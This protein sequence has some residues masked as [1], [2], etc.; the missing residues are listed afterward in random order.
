MQRRN[1]PLQ[2]G[3]TLVFSFSVCVWLSAQD[4][5]ET[6][7]TDPPATATPKTE[8]TAPAGKSG[9]APAPASKTETKP[10]E[11]TGTPTEKPAEKVEANEKK[12]PAPET[13]PSKAPR[14]N[15]PSKAGPLSQEVLNQGDFPNP[16]QPENPLRARDSFY[17]KLITE[18]YNYSKK[19]DVNVRIFRDRLA[20]NKVE[21][22]NVEEVALSHVA[23]VNLGRIAEALMLRKEPAGDDLMTLHRH[24]GVVLVNVGKKI[25]ELPGFPKDK[26]KAQLEKLYKAM[27]K[28]KPRLEK[29]VDDA[30]KAKDPK[31]FYEVEQEALAFLDQAEYL[32][33]W[34]ASDRQKLAV[35][36]SLR[37]KYRAS[38]VE[39][40]RAEVNKR[41]LADLQGVDQKGFDLDKEILQAVAGLRSGTETTWRES[42]LKGP[43]MIDAI[44]DEW[45]AMQPRMLKHQCF[46]NCMGDGSKLDET[47]VHVN[48]KQYEKYCSNVL[49]AIAVIIDSDASDCKPEEV[50][51][52][53]LAYLE[54]AAALQAQL[55]N[56]SIMFKIEASLEALAAKNPDFAKQVKAYKTVTQPLLDWR[57]K[58]TTEQAE[59]QR[60]DMPEIGIVTRNA[61]REDIKMQ[62]FVRSSEPLSI[63]IYDPVLPTL[64]K[65]YGRLWGHAVACNTVISNPATP[66]RMI[67]L[68]VDS[69]Y[70]IM[71]AVKNTSVLKKEIDFLK[72]DLM[73]DDK[74]PALTLNAAAAIWKADHGYW[75]AVGTDVRYFTVEPIISLI[76]ALPNDDPFFAPL[77]KI[78]T[79]GNKMGQLVFRFDFG[80]PYWLR[81]D[82]F[83]C[84]LGLE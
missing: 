81:H 6:K 54:S 51:E 27:E 55:S 14:S 19:I 16:K 15:A 2:L 43:Q 69:C 12:E 47:M 78:P 11:K 26:I 32:V 23:N 40:E 17:Q 58:L 30:L 34:Q 77:G 72:A 57:L 48:S 80:E 22:L 65:R 49:N 7:K 66:D 10:A 67:A 63:Q 37:N 13:K 50:P 1:S 68:C 5:A 64:R 42:T 60:D 8:A 21:E 75:A 59:S 61:F 73:V 74:N 62:G 4:K 3:L 38:M 71:P 41:L 39:Y 44:R 52:L 31:P 76:P 46:T 29:R 84:D 9:D 33:I 28:A 53:Y 82:Y 83:Y 25:S 24:Y 35:F 56:A 79:F 36:T 70:G 20:K 18:G 45:L